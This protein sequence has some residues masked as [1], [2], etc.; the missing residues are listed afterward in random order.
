A[1]FVAQWK[2]HYR[3]DDTEVSCGWYLADL[4]DGQWIITAYADTQCN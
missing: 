4:T 2:D 1:S 3:S